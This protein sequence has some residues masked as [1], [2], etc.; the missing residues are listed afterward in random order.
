MR[1]G[2]TAAVALALLAGCAH[3]GRALRAPPP[4]ATA[5]TIVTTPTTG[6]RPTATAGQA[7]PGFELASP[8]FADGAAIPK[9]HTC[10]G[11]GVSP[12]LSWGGVPEGTAELAITVVDP[13]AGGFVHWVMAAVS[14]Q[15]QAI[16]EG[17]VPEGAVQATSGAGAVGYTPPCPPQGAVHHYVFTLYALTAASGVTDGM[18]AKAAIAAIERAPGFTAI[19]TGTYRRAA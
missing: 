14:P 18:D 8:A 3:D 16:G 17:S 11:E 7:I 1:F 4:G 12:P 6:V 10:D 19:I 2:V 5:P 9:T 13:D 15:V